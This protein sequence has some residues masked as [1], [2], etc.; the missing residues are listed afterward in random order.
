[1]EEPNAEYGLPLATPPE[2]GLDAHIEDLREFENYLLGRG[3]EVRNTRI[4]RYIQYLEH[5]Q[6]DDATDPSTVFKNVEDAR[7]QA[8]IDWYLYVIREVHELMW[9][10][11]GLK[12]QA[13][14]GIDEKLKI[15]VGGR[16]FAA[17]DSDSTSRNL[18][19]ELR[20]A[21]Y[22][23]QGGCEVDLSSGTDVIAKTA[24]DVFFVECK[25]V[26]SRK[27]VSKR[28]SQAKRQLK[29][30]M[31]RKDGN[32]RVLGCVALDV[33]KVA[34]AHNGLTWG[35]T[36][37][38]TRDIIQKEL[39]R[40][41]SDF[42]DAFEFEG[43]RKLLGYWLQIHIPA[44]AMTPPAPMTRFSSYH[45]ARNRLG[46]KERKVM[47][48]FYELFERVSVVD[49]R[50]RSPMP[51]KPRRAVT[52]PAGTVFHLERDRLLQLTGVPDLSQEVAAEVIGTLEI[53]G[54]RHEFTFFDFA[55][56]PPEVVDVWSSTPDEEG[57]PKAD[58]DLLA[59][60]LLRRYPYEDHSDPADRAD[61]VDVRKG[62]RG[63]GKRPGS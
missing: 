12:K 51:L 47:K 17:L 3:I 41:A 26:A 25:R 22:F 23:C 49:A 40:V 39:L 63:S 46:R 53:E 45:I 36:P 27:Q 2:L 4:E 42:S 20:I 11:A 56:L 58:L 57:R 10:L 28:A 21:S 62:G 18:Q 24:T 48:E 6:S 16:D 7:F 54:E 1:M 9:I 5:L 52:I 15:V 34:F 60:L 19:F 38:H 55:T 29:R 33:T 50:A 32:R 61:K 8:P 44:L 59:H 43:C 37:E 14:P 35:L 13:P 30:R 31:P